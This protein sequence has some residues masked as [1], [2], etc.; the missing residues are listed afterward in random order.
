[1]NKLSLSVVM[2]IYNEVDTIEQIVDAVLASPVGELELILVDDG[3]S[4]GTCDLLRDKI[5]PKV[6][7][8]I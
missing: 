6:P 4:D 8:G 2:P 7:R 1:M 5:E 3:S